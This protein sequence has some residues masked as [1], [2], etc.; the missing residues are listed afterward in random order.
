VA[1]RLRLSVETVLRWHRDGKLP[2]IRLPGG[3]VRFREWEIE[4]WL[5]KRVEQPD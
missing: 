4:E 3:A 5:E 2:A 1:N